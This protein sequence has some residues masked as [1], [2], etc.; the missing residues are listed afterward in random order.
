[1]CWQ[2]F[3]IPGRVEWRLD[4]L[5]PK[6][7]KQGERKNEAELIQTYLYG[8]KNLQCVSFGIV[9]SNKFHNTFYFSAPFMTLKV[10]LQMELIKYIKNIKN[11]APSIIK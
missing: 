10:T 8:K 4:S 9:W 5:P 2:P 6:G 11:E 1:M 7:K 3:D